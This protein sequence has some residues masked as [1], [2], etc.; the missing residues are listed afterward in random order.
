MRKDFTTGM[1][2]IV[3]GIIYLSAIL[4]FPEARAGDATGPR[5]FPVLIGSICVIAGAVLCL[6][7]RK[8]KS[9]FV[10]WGFRED[11]KIWK[12]IAI[13]TVLGVAYGLILEP[14]GYL[15]STALFLF[16]I[17]LLVNK[18]RLVQNICFAVGFPV[19]TYLGFAVWLQLS[20]PRGIIES[21]LPF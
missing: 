3:V 7:D 15:L 14:L 17:L 21:I 2:A 19:V 8:K 1:L 18:G 6:V 5:F 11:K 4:W 20:L 10:R 12:M 16:C 13:C 9:D